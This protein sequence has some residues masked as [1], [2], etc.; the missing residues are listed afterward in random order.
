MARALTVFEV[1]VA[2][3]T[4]RKTAL[5]TALADGAAKSFEEYKYICGEIQG[6]S[7]ALMTVETLARKVE[8]NDD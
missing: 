6:L 2:D 8:A 7:F 3:L 4:Q 5:T 1:L